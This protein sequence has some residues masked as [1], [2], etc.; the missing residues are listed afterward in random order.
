LLRLRNWSTFFVRL[1][2]LES[3]LDCGIFAEHHH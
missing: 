1:K 3:I 2:H